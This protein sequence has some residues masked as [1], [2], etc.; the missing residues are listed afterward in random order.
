MCTDRTILSLQKLL[1]KK[2]KQ[3]KQ[4]QDLMHLISHTLRFYGSSMYF[5]LKVGETFQTTTRGTLNTEL[6]ILEKE[7]IIL[8]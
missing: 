3:T 5:N 2:T 8:F 6:L 4:T 1:S 7:S